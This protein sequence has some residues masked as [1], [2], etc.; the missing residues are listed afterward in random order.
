[1]SDLIDSAVGQALQTGHW[2]ALIGELLEMP[3]PRINV[4]HIYGPHVYMREISVPAGSLIV[5]GKHRTAHGC[6]LIKGRL[7]FFGADGTRMEMAA[8]QEWEAGPGRKVAQVLEDTV[9]VNSFA[10]DET[11]VD[12]IE[13]QFFEEPLALDTR[14][15]LDPDGDFER[16]LAEQGA[17]AEAVKR[18]SERTDDLCA[19]P[20]GPYKFKVG[21]SLIEGRG[22]IATAD[23]PA[24]EI[25]APGTWGIKRT[26]VGR[27]AN[28]AKDPNAFFGYDEN[29]VAWLVAKRAISGS[30]GAQGGEE[31]TIDYRCMPRSRWANLS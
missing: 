19:L 31:I 12:L 11:D 21:R 1:M 2:D 30:V 25:I 3:Q 28:H 27:Y 8:Q 26:P 23:T 18:A 16:V 15:M 14:P 5:G 22:L 20:H 9:F 17:T 13:A 6:I 7:Q 4:R 29:R 10:T 24:G